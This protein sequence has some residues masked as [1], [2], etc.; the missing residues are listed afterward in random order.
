MRNQ[1]GFSV[2]DQAAAQAQQHVSGDK[3]MAEQQVAQAQAQAGAMHDSQKADDYSGSGNE[4]W[5][6]K[7]RR[8]RDSRRRRALSEDMGKDVLRSLL[9]G[10]SR[11]NQLQRIG[12]GADRK[13]GMIGMAM[14]PHYLQQVSSSCS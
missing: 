6:A 3:I 5:A 7:V 2:T 8:A 11:L 4:S 13:G 10:K 12:V 9:L 14:H 1:P